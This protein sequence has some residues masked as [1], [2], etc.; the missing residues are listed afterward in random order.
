MDGIDRH[1]PSL[2]SLLLLVTVRAIIVKLGGCLA[3]FLFR[4]PISSHHRHTRVLANY[5]VYLDVVPGDPPGWTL[6]S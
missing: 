1:K 5:K 6:C 4:R 3:T 2:K